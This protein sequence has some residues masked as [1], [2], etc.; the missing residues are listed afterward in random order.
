MVNGGTDCAFSQGSVTAWRVAGF[1][2]GLGKS[3]DEEGS[4]P[5]LV[6]RLEIGVVVDADFVEKEAPSS[7]AAIS[8]ILC[9]TC[10]CFLTG[11][12]ASKEQAQDSIT[13]GSGT[14]EKLGGSCEGI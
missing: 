14:I 6:E 5:G 8:L 11:I 10:R 9:L 4:G 7:P 12:F 2:H 3:G 1:A 13:D